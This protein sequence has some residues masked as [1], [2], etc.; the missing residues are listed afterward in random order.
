MNHLLPTFR[1]LTLT[2]GLS[3]T[4]NR[5]IYAWAY[6]PPFENL[7]TSW[8][9]LHIRQPLSEIVDESSILNSKDINN[10]LIIK[11]GNA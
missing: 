1:S 7:P 2:L 9:T 11:D 4:P 10:K 8:A 6:V 5:R 3:S